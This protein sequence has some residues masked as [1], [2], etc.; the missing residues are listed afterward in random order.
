MQANWSLML[1]AVMLMGV[2]VAILWMLRARRKGVQPMSTAPS[3]GEA[4]NNASGF[5]DII[6]VR[7]INAEPAA[8]QVPT[9][10]TKGQPKPF[11]E[12]TVM[13][14]LLAKENRH[15]AGYELLQAM[16][17]AGLRYGEGQ[18]FHRHQSSNGHGP[19]LFSLAAA[20]ESGV[21]DL[22]NMGGFSVRG[23]CL[24][25]HSSEN[26][27]IDAE[28]FAL[29]VDT[30]KQLS[31]GLGTHL[32]DDRRQAFSNKSLARYHQALNLQPIL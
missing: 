16:L 32:L 12:S 29:L 10:N 1:N 26:A 23:L 18:L 4:A 2:L 11:A 15:L 9:L 14:F 19:V 22:Q 27:T 5:D 31:E 17:A 7:K 3:L 13:L 8:E 28:R 21:F 24:Y 25:M 20:T 30:A 6:A